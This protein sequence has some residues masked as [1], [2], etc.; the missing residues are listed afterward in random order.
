VESVA[1]AV[2]P[3]PFLNL[4]YTLNGEASVVQTTASLTG[5]YG[6]RADGTAATERYSYVGTIEVDGLENVTAATVYQ[7]LAGASSTFGGTAADG[8]LP[9]FVSGTH[10]VDSN[11][12]GQISL[13]FASVNSPGPGAAAEHDEVWDIAL[14]RAGKGFF[15]NVHSAASTIFQSPVD[16]QWTL[17]GEARA[18]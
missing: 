9:S 12:L 13:R 11:Q 3:T 2:P 1:S 10:A 15:I 7:T 14:T 8:N 16:L 17:N 6:F 5:R 18:N 4:L